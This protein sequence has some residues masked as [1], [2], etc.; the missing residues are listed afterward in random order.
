MSRLAARF[1]QSVEAREQKRREGYRVVL[2]NN[3]PFIFID[4]AGL[5]RCPIS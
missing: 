4:M 3:A 5:F 1:H 2:E